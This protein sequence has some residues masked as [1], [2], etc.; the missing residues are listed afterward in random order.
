MTVRQLMEQVQQHHP[1]M[2]ENEILHIA[3]RIIEGVARSHNLFENTLYGTTV[4]NKRYYPL[5][6]KISLIKKVSIDGLDIPRIPE[7]A[8]D[9]TTIETNIT[10]EANE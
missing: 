4:A 2:G 10:E 3:N 1:H 8:I 5:N 6:S 9:D 7:P